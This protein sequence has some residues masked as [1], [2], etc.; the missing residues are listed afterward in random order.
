M[1]LGSV[2]LL[3]GVGKLIDS[4]DARYLVELMATEFYWLIEY[5]DAIVLATTTVE[6]LL[7]VLLFWG[8]R[9]TWALTGSAALLLFF[10]GVLGYFY[11]QGFSVASC[12][13][14]GAFGGGG[15]IEI[16]LLRNLVLL[17]IITGAYLLTTIDTHPDSAETER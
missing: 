12:G 11:L 17:A 13:C 15:G 14:F 1:L 4:G 9:L 5:A 2:F 7:A 16:T 3:S 8:R 6:L 10:A